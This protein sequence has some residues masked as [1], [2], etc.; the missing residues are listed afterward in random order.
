MSKKKSHLKA[1]HKKRKLHP[2]LVTIMGFFA[3]MLVAVA[4]TAHIYKDV[5]P[6]QAVAGIEDS[7][8]SGTPIPIPTG[9]PTPH[10]SISPR[11]SLPP[12]QSCLVTLAIRGIQPCGKDSY[13]ALS[14]ICGDSTQPKLSTDGQ[15]H[16]LT[17]WFTKLAQA[18]SSHSSCKVSGTP[19]PKITGTQNSHPSGEPRPS[20]PPQR[21]TPKPTRD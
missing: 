9:S 21:I 20:F 2:L 8:L 10:P 19:T 6:F 15:C 18:C 11:P 13:K 14:V 1:T 5:S 12:T 16:S 17:A 7:V 4:F 3:V